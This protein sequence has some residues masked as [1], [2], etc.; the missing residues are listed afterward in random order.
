MLARYILCFTYPRILKHI[1]AVQMTTDL[2]LQFALEMIVELEGERW[3]VYGKWRE[4]P[5]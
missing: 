3:L 1:R 4:S 5:I 2:L